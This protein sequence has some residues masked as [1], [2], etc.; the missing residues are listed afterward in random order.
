VPLAVLCSRTSSF[1]I[2]GLVARHRRG[3][4]AARRRSCCRPRSPPG[5]D[6][7]QFGVVLVVNLMIH[8]LTPPLGILVY[9]RERRHAA[10]AAT[11]LFR[12][13]A[14]LCSP[15]LLVSRWRSSALRRGLFVT[16][17]CPS[18]S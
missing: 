9:R 3:D 10:L 16:L 14:A 15:R 12:A 1:S 2:A 11:A 17:S 6:P 13:V 18:R 5:I 7:I 4:P 8:G